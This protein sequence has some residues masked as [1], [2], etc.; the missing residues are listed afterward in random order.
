MKESK[1]VQEF[2]QKSLSDI[3]KGLGKKYAIEGPVDFE[4]SLGVNKSAKGGL[5]LKVLSLGCKKDAIIIQTVNFSIR[6]KEDPEFK[7]NRIIMTRLANWI[8]QPVEKMLGDLDK[9]SKRYPQKNII[10]A[11]K[12]ELLEDE[13]KAEI[14]K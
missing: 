10:A 11:K 1:E 14:I 6:S 12:M 4:L 8:D 9:L 13:Q 5:N 7:T 3:E 2:I